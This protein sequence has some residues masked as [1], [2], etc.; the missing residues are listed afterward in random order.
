MVTKKA[1]VN[2]WNKGHKLMRSA[3]KGLVPLCDSH[4]ISI[5]HTD[6]HDLTSEI[7]EYGG[8]DEGNGGDDD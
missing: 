8:G 5:M 3:I 7:E 1:L 4:E 6:I 2:Q